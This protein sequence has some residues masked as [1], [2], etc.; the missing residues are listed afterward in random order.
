MAG[1]IVDVRVTQEMMDSK[2][3]PP[4]L[5][6]PELAVR[7]YLDWTSY[8]YRIGQSDVATVAMTAYEGVRVDAYVQYNVQKSRLIDQTLKSIEF[9]TSSTGSTS[10]LVPA[11][12][13]W[14]YRYVSIKTA[15]ET[16]S[17][18]HAASYDVT[19]TVVKTDEGDWLVDKVDA[20]ALGKVE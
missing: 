2:P 12:E 19:Y 4:V 18:P 13:T 7:S 1:P 11:K 10:T 14:T 9:G 15:G 8:A 17:G 16:I 5:T 20:K 3:K 6:T